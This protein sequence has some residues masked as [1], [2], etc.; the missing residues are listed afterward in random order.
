MG[1]VWGAGGAG[2]SCVGA[3]GRECVGTSGGRGV[4]GGSCCL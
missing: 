4:Q 3:S 2:R 1:R